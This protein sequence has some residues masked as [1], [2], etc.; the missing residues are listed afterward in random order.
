MHDKVTVSFKN[1]HLHIPTA[2][3][4]HPKEKVNLGKRK[5]LNDMREELTDV[6]S[7]KMQEL[8]ISAK[9]QNFTEQQRI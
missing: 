8:Q 3:F 1:Y 5:V 6:V 9:V 7:E 2:R 4:E